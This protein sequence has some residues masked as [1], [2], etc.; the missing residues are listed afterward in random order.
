MDGRFRHTQ[1]IGNLPIRLSLIPSGHEDG[2]KI[3]ANSMIDE[4][5]EK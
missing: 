4:F 1:L 2:F 5:V 3:T